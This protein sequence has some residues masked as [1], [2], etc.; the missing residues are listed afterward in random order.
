MVTVMENIVKFRFFSPDAQ[1]VQIVG[2]FTGWRCG[3]IH[4]TRGDGGFWTAE[5]PLAEGIFHFRYLADGQW[6]TDETTCSV[7]D[8]P[9]GV[10]S[11]LWVLPQSL[12]HTQ[13]RQ[14][15]KRMLRVADAR[16]GSPGPQNIAVPD[17]FTPSRAAKPAL[18]K[19]RRQM[20][21]SA[22]EWR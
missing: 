6:H 2:D 21:C 13:Q 3:Q 10:D 12:T 14:A 1:D 4:M 9:F 17:R 5:L 22:N 7:D 8:G 16:V 19:P 20:A 15:K 18:P 11:V